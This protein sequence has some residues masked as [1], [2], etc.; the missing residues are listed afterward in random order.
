MLRDGD[1]N[2]EN[3]VCALW[4]AFEVIKAAVSGVKGKKLSRDERRGKFLNQSMSRFDFKN[5][6]TRKIQTKFTLVC[7]F[8]SNEKFNGNF[9]N[10]KALFWKC[11]L[12]QSRISNQ[13]LKYFFPHL[14]LKTHLKENFTHLAAPQITDY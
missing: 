14:H 11:G 12:H 1:G 9:E 5:T 13:P 10:L 8:L 4:L 7:C 2:A 3:I 6:K